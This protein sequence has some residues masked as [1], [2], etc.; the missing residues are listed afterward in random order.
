MQSMQMQSQKQTFY[1]TNQKPEYVCTCCH[2]M[3]FC[4]TVQQFHMKDYDMS[5]ETVKECLS[6]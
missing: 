5:N 4:K 1:G 3:L 6:H 2:C